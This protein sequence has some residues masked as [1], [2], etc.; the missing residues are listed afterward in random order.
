MS[1]R[2]LVTAPNLS[3]TFSSSFQ[4]Y[5]TSDMIDVVMYRKDSDGEFTI[6]I[7]DNPYLKPGL[8]FDSTPRGDGSGIREVG[9]YL[10]ADSNLIGSSPIYYLPA[11]GDNDKLPYVEFSSRLM[12]KREDGMVVK[13]LDIDT[14]FFLVLSNVGFFT[15]DI[16]RDLRD[17]PTARTDADNK[18]GALWNEPSDPLQLDRHQDQGRRHLLNCFDGFG[19]IFYVAPPSSN[20]TISP[21]AS[22]APTNGEG[23]VVINPNKPMNMTRDRY[24]VYEVDA[25]NVI[26]YICDDDLKPMD[27]EDAS[28]L[29]LQQG[30]PVVKICVE[31][32]EKCIREGV[33]L[34]HI[35]AFS[36]FRD[37]YRQV[38]I[39]PVAKV[40]SN[41]LTELHC[42]QGG[43]KCWFETLLTSP[44]FRPPFEVYG[45]GAATLQFGSSSSSERHLH[46][47]DN[48]VDLTKVR[49]FRLQFKTSYRE[50]SRSPTEPTM[51]VSG[52]VDHIFLAIV[53]PAGCLLIALFAIAILCL[54]KRR[55]GRRADE[56][57][58]PIWEK[59]VD[60]TPD[61]PTEEHED[62][63]TEQED[64]EKTGRTERAQRMI[65]SRVR[66]TER[67]HRM[68]ARVQV[69]L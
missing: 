58:L 29:V 42:E 1:V 64:D 33:F 59:D 51:L 36:F 10:E 60:Q 25:Y 19:V 69:S 52:R 56:V 48:N 12:L 15:D 23:R 21:T 6:E 49:G 38:A 8:V 31:R 40:A 54:N 26:A 22:P 37:D 41:Q 9:Y 5:I 50:G 28:F 14:T 66:R 45:S 47:E 39:E 62:W 44:F 43:H 16:R 30:S 65:A 13:R 68:I 24:D 35:D 67:T 63:E 3:S 53:L 11:E 7:T 34:R 18:P 55:Q 27:F 57:D 4:D 2:P 46:E 20:E 61:K 17:L 32:N